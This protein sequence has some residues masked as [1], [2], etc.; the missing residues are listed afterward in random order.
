MPEINT[1]KTR[2]KQRMPRGC[3]PT[4]MSITQQ[5]QYEAMI[6]I[7]EAQTSEMTQ[8]V[9]HKFQKCKFNVLPHTQQKQSTHRRVLSWLLS[10]LD[11]IC[12]H[13][14]FDGNKLSACQLQPNENLGQ[15]SEPSQQFPTIPYVSCHPFQV[16]PAWKQTPIHGRHA[17]TPADSAHFMIVWNVSEWNSEVSIFMITLLSCTSRLS[18]HRNTTLLL[19]GL[20]VQM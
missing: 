7:C 2:S 15:I 9:K 5:L 11:L 6:C 13:D 4:W 16:C 20:P 14:G 18:H 10:T 17:W 12:F 8:F 3:G 1:L 19:L